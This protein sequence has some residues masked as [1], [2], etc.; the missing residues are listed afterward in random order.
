MPFRSEDQSA[1][2]SRVLDILQVASK[3]PPALRRDAIG[4]V[5]RLREHAIELRQRA[6]AEMKAQIMARGQ[7]DTSL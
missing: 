1:L 3:P 4:E 2:E 5:K 7:T 6:A